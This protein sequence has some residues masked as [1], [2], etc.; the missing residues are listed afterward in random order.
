[1][2]R[3]WIALHFI[4]HGLSWPMCWSIAGTCLEMRKFCREHNIR[5]DG[6]WLVGRMEE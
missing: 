2:R 4:K 1:M 3:F 5:R 6:A